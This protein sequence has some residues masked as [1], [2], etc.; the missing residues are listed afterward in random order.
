VDGVLVG[1]VGVSGGS[2]AQDKDVASHAAAALVA[3]A[4]SG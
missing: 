3:A 1:A 4:E 2:A